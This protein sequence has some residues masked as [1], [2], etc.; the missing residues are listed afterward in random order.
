LNSGRR[1]NTSLPD[2]KE[3]AATQTAKGKKEEKK[4]KPSTRLRDRI[5]EARKK[6]RK[7]PKKQNQHTAEKKKKKETASIKQKRKKR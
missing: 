5:H 4:D 7:E 3:K 6:D 2:V 1:P